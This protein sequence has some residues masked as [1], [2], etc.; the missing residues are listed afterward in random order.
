MFPG[1]DLCHTDRAQLCDNGRLGFRYVRRVNRFHPALVGGDVAGRFWDVY[2][3]RKQLAG[4]FDVGDD[5]AVVDTRAPWR[6]DVRTDSRL[7]APQL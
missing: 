4:E 5:D 6:T 1:L 2:E 7:D 3:G